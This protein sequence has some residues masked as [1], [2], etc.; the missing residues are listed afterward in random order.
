MAA[1][2]AEAFGGPAPVV[3]GEYR[4]GDVRHVVASPVRAQAEL[5]YAAEVTFADGMR[6]F[7]T[8]PLR[9]AP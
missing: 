5:G 8:A 4:I 6:E 7:A 1:A 2:L 3:T 9:P